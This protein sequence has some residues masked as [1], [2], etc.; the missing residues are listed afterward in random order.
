M[1]CSNAS[2][3]LF[4]VTLV[5]N[6]PAPSISMAQT[7]LLWP[8]GNETV[9]IRDVCVSHSL[10]YSAVQTYKRKSLKEACIINMIDCVYWI[11]PI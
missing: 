8:L 10:C 5:Q 6:V 4:A 11:S 3:H 7:W 2:F 9:D 1:R